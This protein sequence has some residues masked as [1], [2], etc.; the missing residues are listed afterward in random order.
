MTFGYI[1]C[2]E[3]PFSTGDSLVENAL[4]VFSKSVAFRFNTELTNSQKELRAGYE[5][6]LKKF[7]QNFCSSDR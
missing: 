2:W 7:L 3:L 1:F 5:I 6:S 4:L